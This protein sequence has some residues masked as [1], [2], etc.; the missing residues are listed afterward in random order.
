[1]M[2]DQPVNQENSRIDYKFRRRR[3]AEEMRMQ[4][5][6]FTLMLFLT[7]IAFVA[8]GAGLSKWFVLPF[9][10]LLACIQVL[11]QIYY[12]MHMSHKGHEAPSLFFWS[13]VFVAF[14]TV[15]TFATI[16]WI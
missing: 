7:L 9:V 15:L 3:N 6:S 11:F 13:A 10:L 1:M 16:V 8:V 5:V 2:T 12:F 4:I 14:L